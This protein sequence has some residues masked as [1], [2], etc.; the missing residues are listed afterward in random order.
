[1]PSIA[2]QVKALAAGGQRVQSRVKANAAPKEVAPGV[3]QT[4]AT[5]TSRTVQV[6]GV[7]E[8]LALSMV[9]TSKA[10]RCLTGQLIAQVGADAGGVSRSANTA[11][12]ELAAEAQ[13]AGHLDQGSIQT[14][15]VNHA[16]VVLRSL[17]DAERYDLRVAGRLHAAAQAAAMAAEIALA[18]APL[19]ANAKAQLDAQ[20]AAQAAAEAAK[21]AAAKAAKQQAAD[22]LKAATGGILGAAKAQSVAA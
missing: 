12:L 8:S 19:L 1:M 13:A 4:P 2:A 7:A 5:V 17:K 15:I 9:I 6:A 21:R 18:A 16:D 3:Y 22:R 20:A 10:S 14:W 11:L